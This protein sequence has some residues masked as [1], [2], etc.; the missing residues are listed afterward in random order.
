MTRE[1]NIFLAKRLIVDS[2]WKEARL[3]GIAVTFPETQVIYDN[4]VAN[5][6]LSVDD[7]VAINNLKHSWQFILDT[8][9]Y[10]I[11]LNY[12]CEL[13]KHVLT[14]LIY[15]TE[16]LG[17]LR[18]INVSIGGTSWIPQIPIQSV[19]ED[20]LSVIAEKKDSIT[21]GIDYMLYLMRC[22]MFIDGNK[23]VAQLIANKYMI[24]NGFGIVSIDPS[25]KA[26]FMKLLTNYY[27]TNE[28]SSI[29]SYIQKFCIKT[30]SY[31][32]QNKGHSA[33]RDLGEEYE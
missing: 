33:K 29:E 12:I 8:L 25:Q 24:D 9:D 13:H 22:Q 4:L 27:E 6:N 11:N 14:G 21:K 28:K 7:I 20:D 26:E 2:I 15:N 19:V 30:I 23:R 10:K 5:T 16:L 18:N 31:P 1:E 3:E 32:D 17:N